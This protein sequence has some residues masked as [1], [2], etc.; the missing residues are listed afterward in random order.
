MNGADHLEFSSV[1]VLADNDRVLLCRV[2]GRLVS[3][4]R[5]QTMLGTTVGQRGDHGAL[6][7]TRKLAHM[8][9]LV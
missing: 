1:E 7:L 6:V 5:G 2:D 4:P 9:G 8:L 3:I